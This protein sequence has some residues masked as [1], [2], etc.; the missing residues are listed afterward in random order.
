MAED[1]SSRT[2]VIVGQ[3]GIQTDLD[4][5]TLNDPEVAEVLPDLLAD[6]SAECKDWTLIALEHWRS[7]RWSRAQ[8][9]LNKGSSC[10]WDSHLEL[11]LSVFARGRQI[12]H[13]ALVNLHAMLAHLYLALSRTAPKMILQNA[14]MSLPLLIT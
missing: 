10:E 4:L 9:L 5:D 8:D 12:D 7:G 11:T 1:T 6:Y 2:I 3:G 13:T 14:S